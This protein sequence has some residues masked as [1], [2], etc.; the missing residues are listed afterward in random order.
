MLDVGWGNKD[1]NMDF[2]THIY[3]FNRSLSFHVAW[4]ASY[5]LLFSFPKIFTHHTHFFIYF[6]VCSDNAKEVKPPAS[7]ETSE[8]TASAGD[9]RSL[10]AGLFHNSISYYATMC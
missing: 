2:D 5:F 3:I 1:G 10:S 7:S 9:G 6:Y 4:F 8:A